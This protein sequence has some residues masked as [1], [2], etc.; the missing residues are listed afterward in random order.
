M[1]D[2]QLRQQVIE[3]LEGE[4]SVQAT[5]IGIAVDKGVVTLS[6]HV[7]SYLQKVEAERAV[8]RVKGVKAIAQEIEVRLPAEAKLN[9]D[10][11]AA[12]AVHSIA[13]HASIP[14]GEVHVKVSHGWVT[15]SGTVRWQYQRREADAAV[16]RLSGVRGVLNTI[17][18]AQPVTSTDVRR[19]ITDAL[20]R[21][22]GTEADRIRIA[23]A[24]GGDVTLEGEVDDFDERQAVER[25][26]WSVPGVRTVHDH[27]RI[28]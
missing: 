15:L 8:W 19:S 7:P 10:E 11:I 25:A 14:E 6:G 21:H 24:D 5:G 3:E 23:I 26:A 13:W 22:A 17:T 18:I 4:P 9:D 1:N 27:L 20:R 28:L 16:H 12:R 2:S